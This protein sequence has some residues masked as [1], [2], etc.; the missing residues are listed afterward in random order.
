MFLT[1]RNL[2]VS[3]LI[4]GATASLAQDGDAPV[5][6]D[7]GKPMPTLRLPVEITAE[8][9][10]TPGA[11]IHGARNA[12]VIVTEFFDF[13]CPFC[14]K[15]ARDL[16]ALAKGDA[17]LRIVLLHNAILSPGSV[18]AAKAA[19]AVY[20]VKGGEAAWAFYQKLL[21][22]PGAMN[23]ARALDAAASSGFDRSEIDQRAQDPRIGAALA[24]QME[25]AAACGFSVTP[26][27]ELKGVGVIGHPGFDAMKK[28]VAAV[29]A[30]DRVAC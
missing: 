2:I 26:S 17:D 9:P 19:L 7:K 11:L 13:N 27:F 28:M 16:D 4:A 23:G 12:D 3:T 18:E 15:A 5:L 10:R 21:A 22:T 25:L 30:C 8:F 29:R 20:S 1:R 6:D 24:K 14:R